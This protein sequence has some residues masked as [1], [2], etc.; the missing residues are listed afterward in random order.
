[1]N[2]EETQRIYDTYPL[3]IGIDW[4]DQEHAL[5]LLDT[6]TQEFKHKALENTPEAIQAWLTDI[7]SEH[8]DERIMVCIEKNDTNIK[9]TLSIFSWVDLAEVS[10]NRLK[11]FR[12]LISPSGATNDPSAAQK[13]IQL[14]LH[15]PNQFDKQ[16]P[17]R[18]ETRSLDHH[19]RKRRKLVDNRADQMNQ[20]RSELKKYF[21]Q[22]LEL[23]GSSLSSEMA[24]QFL[25][26][27]PD[28]QTLQQE[29]PDAIRDF[30]RS[31]RLG[32]E[33]I[34]KRLDII[35][36]AVPVTND[37]AV[38]QPLRLL[39][40]SL[41]G[42]V[43]KMTEG[44]QEYDQ[45]LS[46]QFEEH[47]DRGIWSSFPRAGTQMKP[48]LLAA[49]GDHRDHWADAEEVQI[50]SG[51]APVTQESGNQRWVH[52][53][54]GAPNFVKQTFYEYAEHSIQG[55]TWANAFYEMKTEHGDSHQTAV[56]KLAFKWIRIMYRCWMNREPYSE[57]TYIKALLQGG[58]NVPEYIPEEKL[59]AIKEQIS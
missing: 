7:R 32:K 27:W 54:W 29:D 10:E 38:I 2:I 35:E 22:A 43:E 3:V 20:I 56:R 52:W 30:Y 24:C 16:N 23:V 8:P 39:V 47:E 6:D 58:S 5:C 37:P 28:L 12:D 26:R 14:Y 53:R 44:I 50:F 1:M 46:D 17:D 41:A 31:Y 45:I 55:S 11:S 15:F 9:H 21:P 33:T 51:M 18:E 34:Q 13:L 36:E 59:T 57:L 19:A 48:R 49:F 4:A 40:Q 25:Q 42:A